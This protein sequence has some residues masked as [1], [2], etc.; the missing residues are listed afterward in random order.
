MNNKF[1]KI[2]IVINYTAVNSSRAEI[3]VRLIVSIFM[4]RKH[5]HRTQLPP[6]WATCGPCEHH[7]L[8]PTAFPWFES[9]KETGQGCANIEPQSQSPSLIQASM[10]YGDLNRRVRTNIVLDVLAQTTSSKKSDYIRNDRDQLLKWFWQYYKSSC[11]QRQTAVIGNLCLS[12][13]L[14]IF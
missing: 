4:V 6:T 1:I 11:L 8:Q 7:M 9:S 12:Y 2:I 13:Q 5:A 3:G 10:N 14:L